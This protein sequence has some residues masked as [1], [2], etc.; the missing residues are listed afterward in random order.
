MK[1]SQLKP[2]SYGIVASNKA[3]NS[4]EI[5]VTPVEDLPMIDGEISENVSVDEVNG[6][7][8]A[9]T[10]YQE[11]TTQSN[12]VTATWLPISEPNRQTPPDVRRGE[13]VMLY[14]FGDADKY[15]WVTTRS[16]LSLRRLETVIYAFNAFTADGT[17]VNDES[18]YVFGISSHQKKIWLTTSKKNG[19][20]F[21]YA[22]ELDLD[23]GKFTI[24]DDAEN[25]FTL[26]SV[27][28]HLRM[29]NGDGSF[30]ELNKKIWNATAPDEINFNT[31]QYNLNAQSITETAPQRV[32]KG[33]SNRVEAN[34]TVAGDWN[35]EA[36][37]HGVGDATSAGNFHTVGKM[38]AEAGMQ[39]TRLDA[40][41]VHAD[42]YEN[43]P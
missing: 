26:D 14:Q 20:P 9:G 33:V 18:C 35:T 40:E 1:L 10:A 13:Q 4:F 41:V 36:G 32:H 8:S 27:E 21:A 6:T 5:E 29:Q 3:L 38:T 12:T 28:R 7:D 43:L 22:I 30:L 15:Y 39:T 11:A 37:E 25:S 42:S 2:A 16:D 24:T 17:D 34:Q 23:Y 31:K 19:E